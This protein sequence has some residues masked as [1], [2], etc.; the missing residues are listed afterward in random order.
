MAPL[1]S[2]GGKRR[3][4]AAAAAAA[5]VA[6]AV[7]AVVHAV[8]ESPG[9]SSSS[10]TRSAVGSARQQTRE[11]S[12]QEED[13]LYTAGQILLRDC[14]E[15]QG[16]EY[17]PVKQNPV[18]EARDFPYVINDVTWARKHGYGT[19]IQQAMAK[20]RETDP[21][22]RYFRSLP[23]KRRA[24]ALTAANG[25]RPL[26]V[27]AKAPDGMLFQRSPEGCQSETDRKLYG[28]LQKWFQA[29]VTFDTLTEIRRSRVLADPRFA[30]AV[31][32]WA[33]CMR[34]AGHSYSSPAQLRNSLAPS[35]HRLSRKKEIR[36]AVAEADCA[37]SSGLSG[38][39][40]ALDREYAEKLRRQYHSDVETRRRL[41]LTALPRARSITRTAGTD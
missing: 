31:K 32:P 20:V 13:L 10:P 27:T 37:L 34:A 22:Q 12:R 41:Q 5:C 30:K 4:A 25:S 7:P 8:S 21:N 6:L 11:P 38:K 24:A 2:F 14:M 3:L 9:K 39:A 17:R 15:K 29:K 23:A 28:D 26:K 36:L 16:F 35:N 18:P 40:A 33:A 1:R 19:D